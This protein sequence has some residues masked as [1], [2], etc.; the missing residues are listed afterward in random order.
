MQDDINVIW[1]GTQQRVR[2]RRDTVGMVSRIELEI[3]RLREAARWNVR[4]VERG[5]GEDS[6]A[7]EDQCSG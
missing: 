2:Q 1:L 5:I 6:E 4:I 3:D 7:S